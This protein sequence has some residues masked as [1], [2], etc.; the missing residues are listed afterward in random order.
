[1][2]HTNL[3]SPVLSGRFPADVWRFLCKHLYL[4]LLIPFPFIAYPLTSPGIPITLDFPTLDTS[5]YASGKLWVWTEKGSLPAL[6]TI[7]RFPII[8]LWFVLG[9]IGM[10]SVII[11]KL[12]IMLGFFIA[13]FSFYFSFLLLFKNDA[14]NTS[15]CDNTRIRIAT[16]IGA[17]FFA[18]N[19]WSFER[20]PHW[21]LWIGYAIIPLFFVSIIYAFRN[22]TNLK[23]IATSIFL[24]TFASTTPHMTVFYGLIFGIVFAA[25]IL[26]GVFNKVRKIKTVRINARNS[27]HKNPTLLLVIPFLTIILLYVLVNAYWIYPVIL[28]SQLRS[29]SPNYLMVEETLEYLS[30]EAN[31]LNTFRLVTSWQEHP[32]E[33]PVQ[34]TFL[35]NVWYF[36]SLAL[37]IFGFSALI[38]SRKFLKYTCLFSIFAIVG[39]ILAMGTQS[40]L[41]YFKYILENPLLSDYGWLVRD[42]DKW[43]FLI[44]FTYSF[45]IGISSYKILE[46]IG[47]WKSKLREDKTAGQGRALANQV[48]K[49]KGFVTAFFL[50]LIITSLILY[51]YPVYV[52]NMLGE[53]KPVTF[54][55]EFGKLNNYLS[56]VDASNVYFL[57]YPLDETNWNKL[58]RVGNVYQTNSLK[59]NIE[60]SGSTGMAGMGSTNYYNFLAN[61]VVENRSRD[62]RNFIYPLGTSY[63]IF[64]NDTWDNRLNSPDMKNLE[65]LK[66]INSLG[67]LENVRNIGF[68]NIFKIDNDGGRNIT[69]TIDEGPEQVSILN[70]SIAAVGGL[71]TL[72]SLNSLQPNFS[73]LDSSV[74]FIDQSEANVDIQDVLK[75][76]NY[77][78]LEKSPSYIDMLLSIVD[79]KDIVEPAKESVGYDPMKKWSKTGA[80][81]PDN[82]VFHPYLKNRGIDNWQFDYG[83]GL[84]MT[85]AA[86]VNLSM[87]IEIKNSGQFDIF[88]RFLKNQEGGMI[89]VYLDNKLLKQI[90]SW[91]ER[92][93]YFTWQQIAGDD[94]YPLNLKEGRHQLTIE[95]VAGFNA[96][97]MFAVIPFGK[98]T[99]LQEKMA[100]IANKTS[101]VYLLEAESSFYNERGRPVNGNDDHP[102]LSSSL[103][104]LPVADDPRNKT[105][106]YNNGYAES[107]QKPNSTFLGQIRVPNDSN[108]L[109]LWLLTRGQNNDHDRIDNRSISPNNTYSDAYNLVEDLKIYPSKKSQDL[110]MTDYERSGPTIS[111]ADLR[112]PTWLNRDPDTLSTIIDTDNP[113]AGNGSLRVDVRQG[114]ESEWSTIE[115]EFLPI[116]DRSYYNFSLEVSAKD[117]KQLHSR[118]VYYDENRERIGGD[119]ISRGRDGT[120]E[121]LY[122]ASIVPPPGAKYMKLEILVRPSSSDHTNYLIDDMKLEEIR[123]QVVTFGDGE[124]EKVN[125]SPL[126][127]FSFPVPYSVRNSSAISSDV[128]GHEGNNF[129]SQT[130]SV[131]DSSDMGET[132]LSQPISGPLDKYV[133]IRDIFK[134]IGASTMIQGTGPIPVIENSIYN[135]S[136][137]FKDTEYQPTSV[138]TRSEKASIGDKFEPRTAIIGYF[139]NG[140]DVVENRT[141]YGYNASGGSVLSLHPRSQIHADLDILKPANYVFGLRAS[142]CGNC[143]S[144]T[145]AIEDEDNNSIIRSDTVSLIDVNYNKTREDSLTESSNYSGT[146]RSIDNSDSSKLKWLYLN[147]N[148]YLNEGKYRI[149]IY[150]NSDSVVDLDSVVLY[151]TKNNTTS[152]TL[153]VDVRGYSE[154]EGIFNSKEDSLPAYLEEYR[155][156]NPTLYEI[157][158]KNATRPYLMSLAE[159]YDPLW[160]ASYDN[161]N[162]KIS[163]VPLYSLINGFYI[164]KMG[165]Y[166]L[167]LEFQPQIWFVQ[168]AVVSILT[169]IVI[170]TLLFIPRILK[171][172]RSRPSRTSY[173]DNESQ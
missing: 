168:G 40:P 48:I 88:L 133:D 69:N 1:M 122:S 31:F 87:P 14:I 159:S 107:N 134:N 139:A 106:D 17:L 166:T 115:S 33:L 163:S 91:D 131:N 92:S 4:F 146:L 98:I 95:N 121:D 94:S 130:L 124:F 140:N 45:L 170:L 83:K 35:Y 143:S 19:P 6:E 26:K 110:V 49:K 23:Y 15:Q 64:H 150:S 11:S 104:Y 103:F 161:D 28:S 60:S 51:S 129:V 167:S 70:N 165:D 119:Y 36:A 164:N 75:N 86:G 138:N 37:P 142:T 9:I 5:D 78:I 10:N 105:T 154:A 39:I 68:Y 149:K 81:D 20:I 135:F 169:T 153:P 132:E 93:N 173:V 12:L 85:Q 7:S 55:T 63:L 43:G 21:Y 8:G 118:I 100:L 46:R 172:V 137:S 117:V 148:T 80:T 99:D 38:I 127:T 53:L 3:N 126:S 76:S 27:G 97:N 108:L 141:K 24:W 82:G 22:P 41:N 111:L 120:F 61:S 102:S 125:T 79:N 152:T 47:E 2:P 155:K 89:N 71:D 18:Y 114:N 56:D 162:H 113:I 147:G 52:F 54:P 16:I 62:I 171:I 128:G 144:L 156:I 160:M 13:S 84:V 158:I 25:F 96:V 157:K 116:G 109:K 67:G 72:Q 32:F 57:P 136:I 34:G 77:L 29:I 50:F 145:V 74:F 151:S 123:P 101:N 112:R 42:P 58:N 44:A 65:L 30:R 73:S 66:G 59:P 90:N